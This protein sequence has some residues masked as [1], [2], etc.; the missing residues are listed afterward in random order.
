MHPQHIN[1]WWGRGHEEVGHCGRALAQQ[2]LG[3]QLV[4]QHWEA[5]TGGQ[6]VSVAGR[7]GNGKHEGTYDRSAT[8]GGRPC[9]KPFLQQKGL[10]S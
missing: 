2:L 9:K 5:V 3:E 7:E 6:G 1:I 8:W 4:F 10:F